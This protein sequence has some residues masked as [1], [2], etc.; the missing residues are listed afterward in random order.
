MG[1]QPDFT[2][3]AH[4]VGKGSARREIGDTIVWLGDRVLVIS[5]KSRDPRAGSSD[6]LE[7]AIAWLDKNMKKACSQIDGVVRTLRSA[8]PGEI[9]F[10]SERGV[11]VP[12]DPSGV[13]SYRGLIVINY[14]APPGYVPVIT[15]KTPTVAIQSREW[16]FLLN[17]IRDDVWH[18]PLPRPA[19]RTAYRPASRT[20]EGRPW[21]SGHGGVWRGGADSG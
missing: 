7:D 5:T 19:T 20:R 10:T 11:V 2:F 21:A 6:S 9:E 18:L 4:T 12:W 16:E 8:A 13:D 1:G 17:E 15:A 14:A 3:A